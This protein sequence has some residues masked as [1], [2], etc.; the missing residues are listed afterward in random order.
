MAGL[1]AE[2]CGAGASVYVGV[3]RAGTHLVLGREAVIAVALEPF[4]VLNEAFERNANHTETCN[5][6]E[7]REG[8][9]QA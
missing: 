8:S 9:G 4:G 7:W 6:L 1:R 2:W 3:P 5:I